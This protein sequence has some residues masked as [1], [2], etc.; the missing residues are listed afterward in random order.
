ML[1][2][3]NQRMGVLIMVWT[4]MLL[5]VFFHTH[6]M[7]QDHIKQTG[8]FYDN[9]IIVK[10]SEKDTL[11]SLS[12]KYMGNAS[13]GW[14]IA[15]FNGV[16]TIK[17][18]QNLIIPLKPFQWGGLSVN[19]Y[20]SVPVLVYH[21]FSMGRA[22][23][24]TV[25][26]SAFREQM[27]YLKNNGF[28]VV[29]VDDMIDFLELKKQLPPKAVVITLDG[30]WKSQHLIAY[31]ILK[32]FGYPATFFIS[33][34]FIG[35]QRAVSWKNIR[36]MVRAGYDFQSQ[37]KSGRNLVELKKEETLKEY[38][39]SME[40]EV[41]LSKKL[42]SKKIRRN[43]RYLAYPDGATNSLLASLLKKYGY[44]AGFTLHR[45]SNPF[46]VDSFMIRR[47]IIFGDFSISQ[48]KENLA[49]FTE[50]DLK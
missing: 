38:L 18:G 34:D 17:P 2:K 4:F 26:E 23:K 6:G 13:M 39:R 36:E 35:E 37:T 31:P 49:V 20:Q 7:T 11:A 16:D 15:T 1:R 32:Q 3:T 42:I 50:R 5:I 8:H 29:S 21:K 25:T 46:F 12:S 27:E 33:T 30:G 28:H 41:M 10:T 14:M 19:G 24:L 9:F 48:F 44:R 43:C 22:E 45:G 47:S 40:E